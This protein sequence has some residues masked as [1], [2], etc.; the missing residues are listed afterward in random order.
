VIEKVIDC[1]HELGYGVRGLTYSSI[2]GPKGNIE[3][4]IYIS[5]VESDI[6]VDVEQVVL[7]AHETLA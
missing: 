4:L 2:K 1:A 5:N 3:Y 7:Q 6:K